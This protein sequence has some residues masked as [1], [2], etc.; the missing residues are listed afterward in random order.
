MLFWCLILGFVSLSTELRL[1][2]CKTVKASINVRNFSYKS[3]TFLWYTK[4]EKYIHKIS[5]FTSTKYFS[6]LPNLGTQM[7]CVQNQY[8]GFQTDLKHHLNLVR[9]FCHHIFQTCPE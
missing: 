6:V 7:K 1:S 4:K 3:C 8:T 9:E 5:V 2:D